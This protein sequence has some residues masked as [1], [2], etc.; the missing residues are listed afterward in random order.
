MRILNCERMN[1]AEVWK[2]FL[3]VVLC[4]QPERMAKPC[5]LPHCVRRWSRQARD[6]PPAVF[7]CARWRSSQG[8]CICRY[9][10]W[11]GGAWDGTPQLS[12][13]VPCVL[14][15]AHNPVR[16]LVAPACRLERCT[17]WSEFNCS[18]AKQLIVFILLFLYS[19]SIK[20]KQS[21]NSFLS[22]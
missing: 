13:Y 21:S 20:T 22:K 7:L 9:E 2:K 4:T 10:T 6:R 8:L 12:R 5:T 19:S 14:L 1:P 11:R 15:I 3:Y 17:V 16:F 18:T